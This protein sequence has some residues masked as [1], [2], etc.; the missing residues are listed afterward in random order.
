MFTRIEVYYK[1]NLPDPIGDRLKT[2]IA[3]LGFD[4]ISDMRAINIYLIKGKL[5]ETNIE[6]ICRQ[7]L[8]DNATQDY[9]ICNS[10]TQ[11]QNTQ[12]HIIEICRKPGVMDPAEAS[13]R[14]GIDDMGLSVDSVKRAQKYV[15]TG[16]L[17]ND[18][19]KTIACK[20]L[21]NS[22]IE[23]AYFDCNVDLKNSTSV[24]HTSKKSFNKNLVEIID[25]D[26]KELIEISKKWQLSLN[27]H[28]MKA[29]QNHFTS[30]N[31]NPSD[32]EVETIAQTWSEHCV[33]KTFKGAIEYNGE[34]INDL[35]AN[36]IVKATKEL[37][38]PW[39]VSVF[40]DNAGI[41]EFD[42]KYNVCFKVETHN[43][44]SAIEPYGGANTGIGGVIRDIL[45]TGLGGRP[46]FNTDIFCF[47]PPNFPNEDVPKGALHPKRIMKGVVNGVRDYGNRMGIPTLNG[48][49]FFDE[50]YIGNPLV[51]CGT[52]GLIPLESCEK[53]PIEGDLIVLAGGRTGMDGIHGVTFAS[54]GLDKESESESSNAVQIGNPITEKKLTEVL[55]EARDKGLYSC[56]TDC[57]GGGLSSAIGEMGEELGAEIYLDR[58]PLKYEGL[59]YA[60]IW[61]SE[62]QER[63]IISV[64][65]RNEKELIAI[66]E[67]ENVE[68]TTIGRFTGDKKLHLIYNNTTV[69]SLE[70]EFLH[71]GLPKFVRKAAWK[72]S[73]FVEPN[74]EKLTESNK[75][76]NGTKTISH[77]TIDINPC[78]TKYGNDL[79]RILSSWNICSKETVI[80]EYDHEVQGSNVLKPLQ[81]INND[82][83]GDASIV[84]PVFG[85][86]KGVI[87]SN[88]MNP[89]YG[90]I[91]P[92]HMAASAIDEALRQIIAVGGN[93]DQVA[94]LDNFCWGNTE[95]P[96]CL[97]AL[98]RSAQA[99]YDY[100]LQ[101][102]TPFISGKDSLYN[103]FDNGIE[104]ISI[105][106]SLLI[107]AMAIMPDITKAV[108]MDVKKAGNLIYIVGETKTELGGSHFYLSYG[109]TG[110]SVPKVD[111]KL[112]KKIMNSL[113]N[114]SD[115]K[116]IMSCHDCSEG[117]LAVAA[118]EM[119]FA[120]GLGMDVN[121]K[122]LPVKGKFQYDG[123][124]L[125]SESNSRF[126][127]EIDPKNKEMFE[128]A[129]NDVPF[130]L[131]GKVTD[132]DQ[133]IIK[134][135]DSAI[136]V[137]ENIFDLKKYWQM[138]L[139]IILE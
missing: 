97:G 114:A 50:R 85:S 86:K 70:M 139:N 110:N 9:T 126:I 46:I 99:C 22:T 33:H 98:V 125:F 51:F 60:D 53:G 36:T 2:E 91:D 17:T 61:I 118:A 1:N 3:T 32:I 87:V 49:I 42:N 20:V 56:I 129:L 107:S 8:V 92:Y 40:K 135:S 16:S 63:M 130:G 68:A 62:A 105:P 120:G 89:R 79:K 13:L 72:P 82:G 134:K 39:C 108:S 30:L 6:D 37:N 103:E 116:L 35:L 4:T 73:Q 24:L 38:K 90:D 14:K 137:S 44:P 132:N 74:L 80:R 121:I 69:G 55:L 77:S 115:A 25:K 83:P 78:S 113:S 18:Q 47:G 23:N 136:L 65:A 111:A 52:A 95:R 15:M 84:V 101:Y 133:F 117:G 5:S 21:A 122:D 11:T 48:A 127:V 12:S 102:G 58:V 131:I 94:L 57:G 34:I 88:G 138:P 76:Q 19:C 31:R 43:H 59:S 106:H 71:N 128:N 7:L 93:L 75:D 96:E 10:K 45:G 112:G 66:F 124:I 81:G 29:I 100:S 28:E 27:I 67:S 123:E 41:I 119:S 54:I 64:P 104:S 26:D 109:Y